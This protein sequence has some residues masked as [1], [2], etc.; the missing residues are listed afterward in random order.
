LRRLR[1]EVA[2]LRGGVDEEQV[3]LVVVEQARLALRQVAMV[4]PQLH[5]PAV[6]LVLLT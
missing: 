1:A 6:E 5:F 3:A 4:P 2:S